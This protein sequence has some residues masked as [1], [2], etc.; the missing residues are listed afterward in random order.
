MLNAIESEPRVSISSGAPEEN[1]A[2]RIQN[3]QS[4]RSR[5]GPPGDPL[6]RVIPA[7][8]VR[9]ATET[10][11]ATVTALGGATAPDLEN[12]KVALN[13][14]TLALAAGD[15]I[16]ALPAVQTRKG[17]VKLPPVSIRRVRKLRDGDETA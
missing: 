8:A 14:K 10:Y 13:G 7:A 4:T 17:F 9:V 15:Q 2:P 3:H 1:G 16:P 5:T 11:Q 6:D 12:D